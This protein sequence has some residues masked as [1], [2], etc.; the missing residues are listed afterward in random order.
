MDAAPPLPATRNRRGGRTPGPLEAPWDPDRNSQT[1]PCA[2]CHHR[3]GGA[4]NQKHHQTD[5]VE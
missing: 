4:H 3:Q 2:C 1:S 5:T